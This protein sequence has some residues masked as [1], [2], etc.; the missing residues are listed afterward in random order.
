MDKEIIKTLLYS[1]SNIFLFFSGLVF[2]KLS[3]IERSIIM[4]ILGVDVILII[5]YLLVLIIHI[6]IKIKL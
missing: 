2:Y 1:A 6:I 4:L 3:K 5:L